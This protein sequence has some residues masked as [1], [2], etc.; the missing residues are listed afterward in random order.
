MET[1]Q[2]IFD[3]VRSRL[4]NCDVGSAIETAF[5]DANIAHY[6]AMAGET[7]RM[8]AGEYE[9]PCV[10]FRPAISIDGNQWCAL[11][12]DNLQD[13]VAGFGNSPAHAMREFD[14]A[15]IKPLTSKSPS[16]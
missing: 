3:A 11:Y 1:Y 4:G 13:G 15:W 8:V 12:G 9:R 2:P 6:A 10:M 5:R 7:I 14:A 16:P